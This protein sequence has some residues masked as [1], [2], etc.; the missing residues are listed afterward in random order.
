M[1]QRC[2]ESNFLLQ[3]QELNSQPLR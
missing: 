3:V 2:F 1:K